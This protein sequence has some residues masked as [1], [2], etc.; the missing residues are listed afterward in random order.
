MK[1]GTVAC[2]FSLAKRRAVFSTC[3]CG[4]GGCPGAA[5]STAHSAAVIA[6]Q[7]I[8]MTQI[9]EVARSSRRPAPFRTGA[10]AACRSGWL[11]R[12]ISRPDAAMKTPSG[13]WNAMNAQSE[14]FVSV[15]ARITPGY[16][17]HQCSQMWRNQ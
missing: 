7:T 4:V 2:P 9:D 8:M 16:S 3:C 13:S 17:G 14:H 5:P 6:A 1:R 15:V 12:K 11:P 10:A